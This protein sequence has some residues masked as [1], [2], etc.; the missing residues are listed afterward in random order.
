[1]QV[2]SSLT[3]QTDAEIVSQ[4]IYKHSEV[5]YQNGQ[6]HIYP[7]QIN[8]TFKTEKKAPKLGVMLIGWGGNNG[9]TVTGGVLANK[10]NIQ[11]MNKKGVQTPNYYGSVT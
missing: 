6:C 1:M 3:H 10:H 5:E 4:Y 7:K 2:H 9:S 11:W 8:Y